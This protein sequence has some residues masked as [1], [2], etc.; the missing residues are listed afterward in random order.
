M[1]A[2]GMV[3]TPYFGLPARLA[4]SLMHI[5]LSGLMGWGIASALLEKRWKRLFGI[6]ALVATLHGLWNGSALLA[7]YGSLRFV[8][9]EMAYDPV[10]ILAMLAGV[11]LLGLVFVLIAVGLPILN[12]RMQPAQSDIIAPLASQPERTS[13]GLDSQSS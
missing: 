12:R 6:Y 9:Q 5:T 4:S 13:N 10:S 8:V 2:S 3:K 11:T 1:A 7:V